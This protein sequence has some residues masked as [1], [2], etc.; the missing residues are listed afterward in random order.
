MV[1]SAIRY[2][3]P[4]EFHHFSELICKHTSEPDLHFTPLWNE[5]LSKKNEKAKKKK[6]KKDSSAQNLEELN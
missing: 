5:Q 1:S 3:N 2:F 4:L 6:S